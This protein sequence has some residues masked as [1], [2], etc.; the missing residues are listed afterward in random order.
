MIRAHLVEVA[1]QV[2]PISVRTAIPLLLRRLNAESAG[3]ATTSSSLFLNGSLHI[4]MMIIDGGQTGPG[5]NGKMRHIG[6]RIIPGRSNIR[7][8]FSTSCQETEVLKEVTVDRLTGTDQSNG[9]FDMSPQRRWYHSIR[10]D[11]G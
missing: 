3:Y 4:E 10:S 7:T 9:R 11:R 6:G 2:T 5:R 8:S 1:S